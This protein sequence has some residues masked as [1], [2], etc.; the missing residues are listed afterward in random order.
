MRNAVT[1]VSL[2]SLGLVA[3][4]PPNDDPHPGISRA[5]PTAEDVRIDLPENSSAKGTA[6]ALGDL[7]PW[8]VV[9][10]QVTRDLNGGTAWVLIVVHTVVQF[11]PTTVEGDTY[12]WGP[13]SD[14]LDPADYRLVV[15]ALDNGSYDWSLDGRSKTQVGADFETVIAGNAVPGETEGTGHGEFTIDFDAAERVNPVDNDARGVVGISYD[16]AA[17]HLDMSIATVET[18]PEGEVPVNYEYAYT[19]K[20]DGSGDM[21]FA[22]HGDTDDEGTAAEDAVIRSRWLA[23]GAGRADVRLS[24]GD[25]STTISVTASEC[26]D[27]T[28][29]VVYYSDS[30]NWQ[31]TEGSQSSCA[32]ADADLPPE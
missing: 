19:E 14:A 16:L 32:F 15:T 2:L 3:C 12:T 6:E 7:S 10:R 26:W 20:E 13:W 29:A 25:V 18:R 30:V 22:A 21:V 27:S 28:F 5:L 23:D 1:F 31:P 4:I 9:T 11:P 8:Y 24:G 17:R